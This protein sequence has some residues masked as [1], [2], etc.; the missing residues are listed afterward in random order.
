[1]ANMLGL[2][3]QAVYKW[4]YSIEEGGT[5]GLI[6]HRRQIEL[7]V[8]AKQRGIMLSPED[9]FPFTRKTNVHEEVQSSIEGGQN[10]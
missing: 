4:T 6:P 1:V 3:V 8:A 5:G 7:M 10:A 2:S 9:F